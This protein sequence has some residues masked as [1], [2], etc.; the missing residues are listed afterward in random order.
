[1]RERIVGIEH[2]RD[3]VAVV[4]ELFDDLGRDSLASDIGT[5]ILE[6]PL[7]CPSLWGGTLSNNKQ[8]FRFRFLS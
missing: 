8:P 1:M 7:P 5:S 2:H 4:D 3:M 6:Y